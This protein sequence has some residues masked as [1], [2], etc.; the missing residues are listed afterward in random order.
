MNRISTIFLFFVT[1]LAIF[2][3]IS[4][5]LVK[6]GPPGQIFR[7]LLLPTTLYLTLRLTN[8]LTS[9]TSVFESHGLWT[10]LFIFYCLL[11]SATFIA[12]GTL[13]STT[14]AQ[15]ISSLVFSPLAIYFFI[16]L[17]PSHHPVLAASRP[18]RPNPPSSLERLDSDK[19]D[20]LKMV[21]AAGLSVLLLNLFSRRSPDFSF[22]TNTQQ[23]NSA[24]PNDAEA[25]QSPTAN[26]SISQ[27]DDSET[28]YFGFTNKTGQWY[29]MR[30]ESKNTYRYTRGDRDFTTNW[31]NRAVLKYDLFENVF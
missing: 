8:H 24:Q 14:P 28:A 3:T 20:F 9:N 21:G 15:F 17:L 27:I 13:G 6:T 4:S 30:E 12:A 29:I 25:T 7:I 10:K 2:I 11:V 22:L 31:T 23:A 16:L 1:L 5:F 19:R 18:Y 26:Y